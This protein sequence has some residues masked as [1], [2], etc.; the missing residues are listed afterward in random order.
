MNI[1]WYP[2]HMTK[3]RRA[4]EEDLKLV[5]IV[6]ELLDA[7]IPSSSRNP[8]LRTMAQ[9]KKKIVILNKADLADPAVTP[10]W[11]ESLRSEGCEPIPLDARS[12][13]GLSAVRSAIDAAAREKR[14]RD[15]RRGI[16]NRPIRLMV[17]G[18]PNVGKS[19]FINSLA[20]KTAAKTG[21]KPGVTRGNQWI[22][23]GRS[24][25][26]L[27]TP[28]ILWPRFEDPQVGIRL[29]LIGSIREEV[30]ETVLLAREGIR[31]LEERYPGKVREH[32]GI[33]GSD[34]AELIGSLAR[35]RH[36]VKKGGEPDEERAAALF[37][38]DLRRSALGRLTL[39]LPSGAEGE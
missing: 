24:V 27:D 5:D 34:A 23:L 9:S 4:M 32:Y 21:D 12:N 14:E 15:L 3:A 30:L 18:I 39:E 11:L 10:L 31:L 26:L 25:D 13:T 1:Q 6:V 20:G 16:K 37:L 2:G 22:S 8:D 19:T 35:V 28:G 29:A 36:T 38:N 17:A 33:E 7:R